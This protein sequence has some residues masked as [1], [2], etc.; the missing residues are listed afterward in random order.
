MKDLE[1]VDLI[2][3]GYEWICPNCNE[4]NNE[5]EIT[6]TVDCINCDKEFY[7]DNVEHAFH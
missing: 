1:Y 5:M 2:S 6:E 7:V 3:T 4:L